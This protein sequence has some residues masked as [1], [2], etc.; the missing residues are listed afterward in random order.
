M[1]ALD[2]AIELLED[3]MSK[4]KSFFELEDLIS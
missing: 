2:I 3:E 1:P 4:R